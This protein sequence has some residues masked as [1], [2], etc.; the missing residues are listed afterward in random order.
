VAQ[1]NGTRFKQKKS[2]GPPV[3]RIFTLWYQANFLFEVCTI[4]FN[5]KTRYFLIF[6]IPEFNINFS[7]QNSIHHSTLVTKSLL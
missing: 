4:L 3:V 6:N 7:L 1:N 5:S 2:I